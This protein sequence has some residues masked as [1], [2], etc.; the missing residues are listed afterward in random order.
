MDSTGGQWSREKARM[1][2][3]SHWDE[4]GPP[5]SHAGCNG[6]VERRRHNVGWSREHTLVT[7][8]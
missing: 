3:S 7:M 4:Q 5:E 6:W 1:P 2:S 8:I